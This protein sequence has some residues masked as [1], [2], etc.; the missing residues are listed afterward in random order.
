MEGCS[1][2]TGSGRGK[3][4]TEQMIVH[5]S[6]LF[7]GVSSLAPPETKWRTAEQD[8]V[9]RRRLLDA[10]RAAASCGSRAVKEAEDSALAITARGESR[11]SRAVLFDRHH[12]RKL[13]R[14]KANGQI[15]RGRRRTRPAMAARGR[16]K[17]GWGSAAVAPTASA[18]MLEAV[19]GERAGGCGGLRGGAGDASEGDEGAGGG[20]GISGARKRGLMVFSVDENWNNKSVY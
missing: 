4:E 9:F 17:E 20:G 19:G 8:R 12:R 2:R 7:S 5:P 10:L 1:G 18:R 11:W 15:R 14:L 16:R 3:L 6:V 13:L